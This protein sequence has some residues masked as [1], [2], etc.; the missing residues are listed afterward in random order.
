MSQ[1]HLNTIGITLLF[2]SLLSLG[3]YLAG[4]FQ[5]EKEIIRKQREMQY[6]RDSLEV[7]ELKLSIEFMKERY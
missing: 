3:Y 1:K 7:E 2:V 4:D 5:K 6:Y